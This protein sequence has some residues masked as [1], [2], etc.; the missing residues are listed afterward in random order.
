M[1]E[2]D[3]TL[4]ELILR[5]VPANGA[6]I[7]DKALL[8]RLAQSLDGEVS[9]E[10]FRR[11]RDALIAEGL[12]ASGRGRGGSV[13]RAVPAD[14][15]GDEP[16]LNV[17][18]QVAPPKA[19]PRGAPQAGPVPRA[20]PG[21]AIQVLSYRHGDKRRNNPHVGMVDAASDGVEEETRWAYDPHIDPAL[22]FDSA[23]ARVENLIDDALASGDPDHMRQALQ[24][25]K[26][27]QA[28]YLNWT[29]KAERTSFEVD[30]VSLHVHERIDP[31]TIIA[32]V[33]KQPKNASSG[34][35]A[36]SSQTLLPPAGEGLHTPSPAAAGTMS[37]PS[38]AAAGTISHPSPAG[39]RGAGVRAA[40]QP[41]LFSAPFENLPLREA[42]AFYKHERDWANRLIAGDSLLVM[43]SLIQKESMAGQV[44]M[45]YIDPPYGIKYG[46]NF[47]PF[48]NK[49]DVKDR[50]DEDLTQEPEMIK[51]FRDTWEL[52]IHSYLTYLR[53]RLLLARELLSESGS[54][55]VQ[56]S[57]ENLHHVREVMDE[58]FGSENF[59]A[60]ITFSKTSGATNLF[61]PGTADYL[62][63]YG[64]SKE[65]TKYRSLY[66]DKTAGA[67]GGLAYG[68]V[69]FE[70]GR[71]RAMTASE[72][73]DP[74]IVGIY[75]KVYRIDNLTSQSEGR[76]KG[77]GA[78][79]WFP[80]KFAG[81]DYLP[82]IKGRWKTNEFGMT[83]LLLANR[84]EA[85]DAG[86]LYY[87]RYLDDFPAFPITNN[88]TDTGLAGFASDKRYVVETS[89]KVIER[90]LLMTTDPGDLVLDPTCG[91]GTTAFVAEKWGRRWITC[92]TSR[93]AVT[94]AKQRLLTA[95]YDYYELKYPHEGLKGGFIYKTVPHVTLKSIANNPEIDEIYER[96]HPAIERALAELNAALQS[97]SPP[98]PL[99]PAGEGK[100]AEAPLPSAEKGETAEAPLPSAAERGTAPP[101]AAEGGTAPPS[102]GK[103]ETALPP[104]G[105]GRT[106][107]PPVGE[108]RT[109]KASLAPRGEGSE[110]PSPAGGRA[111]ASA[112]TETAGRKVWNEST[113]PPSPAGGRGAGG[114]GAEW[115]YIPHPPARL[116]EDLKRHARAMR[117]TA[118]DAE[119]L[120]W[121]LLRNRRLANAKF[122][123]QHPIGEY[124]ADFYC[125]EHGLVVELD[126]GQ[127][128]EQKTYDERRTAFLQSQGLTV[129]RFW[130]HQVLGETEAVLQVIWEHVAR[131]DTLTPSP[132]PAYGRGENENPSPVGGRGEN[133]SPSPAGGRRVWDEGVSNPSATGDSLTP[134][135]LPP[136][137]EG[138]K[139]WEVPFDFP[140]GWPA[141]ARAP[142]DA[143]HAARQAM[144]RQMDTSIAAHADQETLYDQP[145]VS[146]TK[147][148]IT[149]P[150]T[151]E[152]VPF[153]TV[154]ALEPSP[155]PLFQGERDVG[156]VADTAVARSGETS[157]QARWRDE[158]LKTGIRGKGGQILKLADL[159]PL[160]GA[161]YVHAVG[162]VAEESFP[163]PQPLSR[164]R[165]RGLDRVAV[166]FG[167]E[168]AAL[169]QRQVEIAMREAG[170]LFPLPKM[171][172]FCA[173]TFDPEAAKDIDNIKGI[174]ALKV[175]MNTDLLT[176][177][178]KKARASNESFWL[179]G[180]PDVELRRVPPPSPVSGRGAGGEGVWY[181]VEVHGFDYFDTV[182]GELKS[183][184]KNQI[185]LWLLDTDYDNRSLF[186]RQVFFPMAGAKDGWYKLKKDIRAEL[187]EDLLEQFH[188]TVSLP[189]EAGE[190]RCIAVKIVDDRGIESLKVMAL[191]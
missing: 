117:K 164:L 163:S 148:R 98:A 183:G 172:V 46:S 182:T 114:E 26:R 57:D 96:M 1:T 100:T 91:S 56:I 59:I 134:T 6:S 7:G 39:G 160:P 50:R 189:F 154:L 41:D 72:K 92:D 31:A 16:L 65:Q 141:S 23:R 125:D 4:R 109:A 162:T 2:I 140:P 173:F 79:C 19:A 121:R 81:K 113:S 94:L 171:L 93:V 107:P 60:Q 127:H 66:K 54:V 29:G 103:G 51:A 74:S 169:E 111:V 78:A 112:V 36:P 20:R 55:F 30:T 77:E 128:A 80:V 119:N 76:Q 44:Q 34:G 168:H 123:R 101:S 191:D 178:L 42:I 190:N 14:H 35:R 43:N 88:W 97:P 149:G 188:G 89:A 177:D 71:R 181:Q 179:M 155:Q 40:F 62:L 186:P 13:M 8:E 102:M 159:E 166:S 87:V 147:L 3:P 99:P 131:N 175:Q 146:K 161:R 18:V 52:G 158:L 167:P 32:A 9:E 58:I 33:Q 122:R 106:T 118:T 187:D 139:E 152:A 64:K 82:S 28:P 151:V 37:H 130:N 90:C 104:T 180:Q 68:K 120:M 61:L 27:M 105:E 24:Q 170:E 95:S 63:W 15:E 156:F 124:I 5:H 12:L 174:T 116:P 133:E 70:D 185:A 135:P 132:S 86:G 129:L 145:L 138:L 11:V 126:G 184:G 165:E 69:E 84:L 153:P 25:L 85:T 142:F 53:D 22:Q 10:D 75:G 67:E 45:I 157:R 137:G 176:E 110:S 49:R 136:T 143:F 150:F 73:N 17:Q 47:Q 38:P 144:Q 108:G 115:D 83:R 48:V 21:D